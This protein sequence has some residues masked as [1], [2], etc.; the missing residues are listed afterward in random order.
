MC[1]H[2]CASEPSA[3]ERLSFCFLAAGK[4][5]SNFVGTEF[6]I[7]DKG[8]KPTEVEAAGMGASAMRAELGAVVYQ[9]NVLG[10]RGPRKM[11]AMIPSVR[12][13]ATRSS[14]RVS[15][16][17]HRPHCPNTRQPTNETQGVA[18]LSVHSVVQALAVGHAC[19]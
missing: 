7:Y 19:P 2:V 1:V 6:T 16:S 18:G 14:L 15:L 8:V 3:A 12:E 13:S 10:T 5:R 11:T 4:L 9:Y 17:P